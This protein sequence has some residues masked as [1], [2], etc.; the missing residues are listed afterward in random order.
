[1][2]AAVIM[3]IILICTCMVNWAPQ[4]PGDPRL[5]ALA[6]WLFCATDHCGLMG[7]KA[8]KS[9]WPFGGFSMAAPTF[10]TSE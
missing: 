2:R 3:M 5:G 1:M 7:R 9:L 8:M 6:R 4:S 10:D